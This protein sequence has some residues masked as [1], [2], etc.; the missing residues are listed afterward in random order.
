MIKKITIFAIVFLLS[1]LFLPTIQADSGAELEINVYTGFMFPAPTY[2]VEN[3][4]DAPAHNVKITDTAVE[5]N[6]LYNNRV[7]NIADIIEPDHGK[8]CDSNSLFI[9]F[10]LFSITVTVTCD[11][12]VFTSSETNGFII[13]PFTF[14]P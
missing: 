1:G 12:G 13:G 6:I 5:G 8:N 10:G 14:I 7:V 3:I 4:G 2:W 9:G 11:E